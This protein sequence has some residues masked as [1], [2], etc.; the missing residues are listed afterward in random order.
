MTISFIQ[1]VFKA[2]IRDASHGNDFLP[3]NFDHVPKTDQLVVNKCM[4]DRR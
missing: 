3:F 4:K 2:Q 1:E